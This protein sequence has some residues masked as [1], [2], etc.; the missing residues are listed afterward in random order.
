[1]MNTDLLEL[2]AGG[3]GDGMN[4][5][6]VKDVLKLKLMPMGR[7]SWNGELGRFGVMEGHC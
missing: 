6:R 3:V 1:M 7:M 5:D 2:L 4:L